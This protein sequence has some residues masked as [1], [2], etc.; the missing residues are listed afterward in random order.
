MI[1]TMK[2]I[3]KEK[4]M[5]VAMVVVIFAAV[6]IVGVVVPKGVSLEIREC[7]SF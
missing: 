2:R 4:E 6:F 5:S 1:P 3:G 7:V